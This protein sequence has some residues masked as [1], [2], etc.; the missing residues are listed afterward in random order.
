MI[1]E[2]VRNERGNSLVEMGL[3]APIL[4]ALLLGMS[5]I[6]RAVSAKL[7]LVQVSQRVVE[8]VQRSAF[9]TG[10][11]ATLETEAEAAAGEG[12]NATVTAWLEC[13]SST[14]KLD[15]TATCA[16]GEAYARYMN[17]TITK[18]FTPLFASQYFPGADA[19]GT[20]TLSGEAG[21]RVQ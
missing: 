12:S 20:Y 19:N 1:R 21:V 14:T 15:Y 4:A 2:L 10:T 9:N 13:G 5:D 3:A 8:Q 6:S 11:M 16:E 18:P 17:I 7:Q